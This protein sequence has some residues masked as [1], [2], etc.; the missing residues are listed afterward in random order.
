[1]NFELIATIVFILILS[2]FLYIKRKKVEIQKI[3]FPFVYL[4]L[5]KT[6]LGL[7]LMDSISK[8]H[9]KLLKILSN[10]GIVV[11][12]LGMIFISYTLIKNF[13]E[14][15]FIKGT[16]S[17]MSMVLPIPVKGVFYVPFFYWIISIFILA[18]VH[19]FSHG[20]IARLHKIKVN[21]SGFG[22]FSFLLPAIPLAFVEPDQ[23][24]IEKAKLSKKL[25]VFAAGPFSNIL[26]GLLVFVFILFV[27]TPFAQNTVYNYDGVSVAGFVNSGNQTFPAELAGMQQNEIIQNIDGV[28]I[29]YTENFSKFLASKSPGDIIHVKTNNS[30][31]DIELASAPGDN[32]TAYFG[33]FVSQSKNIQ[34]D[35][36]N[37]AGG[38]FVA[39]ITWIMGLLYWL[40]L[41]NI[42]IGLFNL[43]PLGPVDGGLMIR[44][45]LLKQFK[46]KTA[47]TIFKW[48]TTFFFLMLVAIIIYGF[49]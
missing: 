46:K 10:I 27:V 30:E 41:L 13:A 15:I 42:G 38:F 17:S 48:I 8:K 16:V 35:F 6:K 28:D 11:G 1:M 32:Q 4:I 2:I 21:S 34:D 9:P 5:L 25:A 14:L 26:L 3:F 18:T 22:F 7:K 12:F 39:P 49:F 36:Q 47:L 40:Y 45:V 37:F 24:Q 44:A 19:E 29:L 31:Y 43:V 33:I 20:V 23:K